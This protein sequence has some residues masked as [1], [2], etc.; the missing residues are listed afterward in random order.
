[1]NAAI[2]LANYKRINQLNK[3]ED[4]VR[5]TEIKADG[6]ERFIVKS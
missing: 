1:L 6:E 3:K 2:N 5:Y 4:T